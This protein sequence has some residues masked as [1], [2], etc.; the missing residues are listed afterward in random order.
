MDAGAHCIYCLLF[1]FYLLL[2]DC[3]A[4][5]LLRDVCVALHDDSFLLLLGACQP[6][7]VCAFSDPRTIVWY[8]SLRPNSYT[9]VFG[10]CTR[11]V[12]IL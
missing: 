4:M 9:K 5:G 7:G 6:C 10:I 1:D 11:G 8:H 3:L 12:C 2:F